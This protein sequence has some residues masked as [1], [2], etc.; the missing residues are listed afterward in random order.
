MS[1]MRGLWRGAGEADVVGLL[2]RSAA[3]HPGRPA[4]VHGST[5]LSY[6]MLRDRVDGLATM[7][8]SG[9][10]GRSGVVA[11]LVE[12]DP[13][14]PELYLG[15]MAAGHAV[16]PISTRL[17]DDAIARIVSRAGC[18]L[19]LVAPSASARIRSLAATADMANWVRYGDEIPPGRHPTSAPALPAGTAMV[20]FTSGTTGHPKGVVLTHANLVV[21]A[22]TAARV[23]GIGRASVH[24][25][26]MPMAHFAG[27]SRVILGVADGGTH[28]VLP[29]FEPEEVLRA[30]DRRSGTH[31]M[32]VPTMA[33]DLLAAEPH[34]YNLQGLTLIY[35]AA[36]MPMPLARDL[37]GQMGCRLINGY[38]LTESSA[39]A[40]ALD[41]DDHRRAVDTGD[42]A[43]LA[44][45]GQPVPGV[46]LAVLDERRQP[47]PDGSAGE[48][49]LRGPKV[50]PGYL[51]DPEQDAAHF[52]DD[53][54]LLTGDEGRYDPER[55][56]TLLGRIDDMI[57]SGGLNVQPLEI[58]TQA[59]LHG[60]V[61]ECAAFALPHP[62][63]GQEVR[64]AV[65][66]VPGASVAPAELARFLRERLDPYK[67]P[68]EIHVVDH[69]PRTPVGKL[70]RSRLPELVDA[71]A[72]VGR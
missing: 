5:E 69:L 44:T 37:V 42:D 29:G 18:H 54:W 56:L 30:V 14:V 48:I 10:Y 61:A 71:V 63:W 21:H 47:V 46:E 34:R 13:E 6:R 40:T 55:G 2:R 49:A 33:A 67:V 4:V 28:V 39:L 59:V 7:L 15:V 27:A 12:H 65:V 1:Y 58:E 25:N 38:G 72:E 52:T 70:Q 64:L 57:I 11:V 8:G 60:S 3:L 43:L 20:C 19:G 68:K 31:L 50:S 9:R 35:G 16:L 45:V 66:A 26:P 51:A 36:P 41:A 22:L 24:V 62:R 17:P 23:Y 53:G 32:V